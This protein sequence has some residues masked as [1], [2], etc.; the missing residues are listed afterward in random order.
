MTFYP[1][2]HNPPTTYRLVPFWF[3]NG[4][5]D[6]EEITHQI[7]EMAMKGI[8][9]FFI[10][11]RQGL[12]NPYLSA[13]WFQYVGVAVRAAQEYGLEVWLY[14]E[15]PYPSGMSS[16]EVTLEH[17]DAKHRQLLHRSITVSG[18]QTLSYDLP[19]ARVLSA[20]AI[21]L[22]DEIE[23]QR[24]SDT[25]DL[26]QSI[27]SIP[28]EA[29]FQSTG[30]TTYTNKR[31]F[32]TQLQKQLTWNV[33]PGRW[34]IS[35]FLE[36]EVEDFKYFG[37]Y[38]DP[39]HKEAIQTFM[40]TTHEQYA[41]HFDQ[42]FGQTI[43]GLFTDE[44]GMLGRIPWSARLPDFFRERSGY[45]L[46][47]N[48]PTL[49]YG[50]GEQTAQIRYDFFQ[51]IHRL[52][53]AA[54]YEP[55]SDWCERHRLQF[56]TEVSSIRMTTQRYSHVPGGDSAHE[57][58]GRSLE[59]ILNR[60]A[61]SLR[62][63]PKIASSMAR[64][65]GCERAMIE[66]FHSVGWSMTL[67]DAKW[68]L[69]RLAAFGINLFIFHAFFYSISGLRKHDAPPSQFL[70]NPYWEHFR[71]L[72]DYAG[73]LGYI[74]SQ[75]RADVSIAVVHP[76]TTFWTRMGNAFHGFKY[77]GDNAAE[78][79]ELERLKQDWAYLRNQLLLHQIDY[80]HLDPELLAEATVE[81]GH[82][83]VGL[84]RYRVLILPPMT[85]L[86]AT[87]WAQVKA[88]L[89]AG[90]IVI[91]VGLLPYERIDHKQSI[92][93]E[94]LEEFALTDSPSQRYWQDLSEDETS[95]VG[96]EPTQ[97]LPWIKGTHAAY[98]IPCSGGAQRSQASE[99]LLTLLQQ[100]VP[101]AITLEAAIGDRTSLLMQQRILPDESRLI[102]IAHQEGTEKTLRLHLA[103]CPA[104]QRVE[105]LDLASGEATLI[106]VEKTDNGWSMLLPFAPYE[107]HLLHF[108][109]G[110]A[111]W[112]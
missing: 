65:L 71:S 31:F 33:P 54:Y 92:E 43:K 94:F 13:E 12:K 108:S 73:R 55:V 50:R 105:H 81:D 60:Y 102:F 107:S 15:Y 83:I 36:K 21:P 61:Y 97:E 76:V 84:A 90:G 95:S 68:M 88:F 20:Q 6:A 80:D 52:L 11:A 109:Y 66:C 16:G 78:E 86:E 87:A 101:P 17:P 51:G 69:D 106:S 53:S 19:W 82:L 91:G 27:G 28:A 22:E 32:T 34:M 98:F 10:C 67:Q 39:C 58:V 110:M 46:V 100:C 26:V 38:V 48:L 7:E 112:Q 5:M 89:R 45:D 23:V 35:I 2:F 62:S 3:W 59:W 30:L 77:C 111:C 64:Q 8:G 18:P 25:I 4:D 14:D 103:A 44:V 42:H 24:W 57:K 70:Q 1:L 29:V 40:L 85:N 99:R 74:M 56:V 75:G 9:G 37:H 47:D 93:A 41:R 49:L 63:D 72:A 104:G 79:R 96:D